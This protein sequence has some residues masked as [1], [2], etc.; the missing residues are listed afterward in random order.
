MTHLKGDD[1]VGH[2]LVHQVR[3]ELDQRNSHD[4]PIPE[5]EKQSA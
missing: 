1:L 3:D 4:L 5:K 2:L